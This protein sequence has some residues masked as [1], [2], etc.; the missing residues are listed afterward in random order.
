MLEGERRDKHRHGEPDATEDAD[1]K[2]LLEVDP[3]RQLGDAQLDRQPAD[4]EH[5]ERLADKQPQHDPHRYRTQQGGET[6]PLQRYPGVGKGKQRQDQIGTPGVQLVLQI[7]ER[8]GVTLAVKRDHKTDHHT[9]QGRMDARLEHRNPEHQTN[10]HVEA[11]PVLTTTIHPK[12]GEGCQNT[13]GQRLQRQLL[14]IEERDDDDDAEVIHDGQR[15]QKYLEAH[16]H[17]LAEQRHHPEG[18]GDVGRSRDRPASARHFIRIVEKG[19]DQGRGQHA[20]HRSDSR[21]GRLNPGRERPFQHL[22][23]HFQA[24]QQEEDRHKAIVD[25]EQ[26]WLVDVESCDAHLHRRVEKR[27]IPASQRGIG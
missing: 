23:L 14:G 13:D 25:P 8:R 2:N 20:A 16:R 7:L 24:N 1:R 15:Q 21:E 12:Q 5:P 3:R 27:L 10:Q 18:K 6:N 26:Q 22:S 11:D 19:V 4:G 17:P 9:G